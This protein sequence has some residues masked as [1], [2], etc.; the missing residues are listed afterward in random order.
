MVYIEDYRIHA[1]LDGGNKI[2][3]TNKIIVENLGL[4]INPCQKISLIDTNT[5]EI[6]IEGIIKNV[7]IFIKTVIIV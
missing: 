1:L 2:N 4:A 3:I 7:P 6:S 5:E